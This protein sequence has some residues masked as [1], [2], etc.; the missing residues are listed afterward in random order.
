MSKVRYCEKKAQKYFDIQGREPKALGIFLDK[1]PESV[2]TTEAGRGLSLGKKGFFGYTPL[3]C[4]QS[5]KK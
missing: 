3:R 1:P 5:R 2:W 4:Y